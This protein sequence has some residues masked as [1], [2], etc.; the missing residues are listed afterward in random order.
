M[1]PCPG[2]SPLIVPAATLAK[3]V[4]GDPVGASIKLGHDNDA[5]D[6]GQICPVAGIE[7]GHFWPRPDL[8]AAMSGE[9]ARFVRTEVYGAATAAKNVRPIFPL[10]GERVPGGRV[11]GPLDGE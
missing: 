11:R 1:R 5:E 3:T 4:R 7:S 9:A 2:H 6:S 10:Q 8:S